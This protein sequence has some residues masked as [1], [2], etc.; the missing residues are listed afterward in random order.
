MD[1]DTLKFCYVVVPTGKEADKAR[2]TKFAS[3]AGS[4][5]ILSVM[6]RQKAK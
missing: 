4:G 3:D 1:G 5:H 2:P 6:K